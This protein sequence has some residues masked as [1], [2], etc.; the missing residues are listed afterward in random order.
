MAVM[1]IRDFP[2]ELHHKG[3]VQ[4]ALERISLKALIAKALQEYLERRGV[5]MEETEQAKEER[6]MG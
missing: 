4:A 1:F 2:E 3:K 5:P 6:L